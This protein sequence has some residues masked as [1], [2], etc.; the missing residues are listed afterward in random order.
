MSP[1]SFGTV[2]QLF[3]KPTKCPAVKFGGL[4]KKLSSSFEERKGR[5]EDGKEGTM[6][7]IEEQ[8]LFTPG[9]SG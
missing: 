1:I 7:G 2:M 8:Q 5:V 9:S 6:E 4:P 3:H